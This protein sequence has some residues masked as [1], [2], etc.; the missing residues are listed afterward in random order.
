M[1]PWIRARYYCTNVAGGCRHAK[2]D[3]PFLARDFALFGGVCGDVAGQG[4]GAP[5]QP[6]AA[7]DMRLR[8]AALALAGLLLAALLG[9]G[10]R[11]LLFP[12]PVEHV[13]FSSPQS[14][15]TDDAGAVII[16]VV[17]SG[18]LADSVHIDYAAIDG[19]AKTGQDFAASTGRLVFAPGERSKKLAITLLPD[20]TFQK[21]RR[22]F[23]VVLL[24]V[25]GEPQHF[26]TIGPRQAARSDTLLA[27]R[28]VM[29][30]SVVA[31][32]LAD[33]TV[34]R[35]VLGRLLAAARSKAGEFAEY[36]RSLAAVD[37]NLSRARESYLQYMRDLQSQQPAT[38]LGAMDRVA[39]DLQRRTFDQQSRA[40]LIMKRQLSE[41]FSHGKAD[42]DRWV[43]ELA[44]IVPQVEEDG[45]KAPASA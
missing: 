3:H 32:D 21:G 36:Q 27:E 44:R 16:D 7:T 34:Q 2:G 9:A 42:M 39:A 8:W 12:P 35:R 24:N 38:V 5:L 26:V 30:A 28:S 37:G 13:A 6:G 14:E 29:A 22:T 25:A 43:S 11:A 41:L 17:R 45:R 20:T 10:M 15:S 4:C 31:K 40:L 19:S 33:L 18:M 1:K 23:S